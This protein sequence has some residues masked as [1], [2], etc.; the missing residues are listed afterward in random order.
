M[1]PSIHKYLM[2]IAKL[3]ASR[4]TCTENHSVGAVAT[5]DGRVLMTG[6]NGVINGMPHCDEVGCKRLEDGKHAYLLHA[7]ENLVAQACRYGISLLG[8]TVYTTWFPCSHCAALLVQAGVKCIIYD[9]CSFD[10]RVSE[11][12]DVCHGAGVDLKTT[13][14]NSKGELVVEKI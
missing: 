4:S 1:R 8:T 3:A 13:V 6:Y 12:I 2:D 14:V 7:E 10:M 9:R 5:M 11:T